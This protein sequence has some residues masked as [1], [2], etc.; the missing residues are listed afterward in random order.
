MENGANIDAKDKYGHTILTESVI[1][2]RLA[3]VKYLVEHGANIYTE[4]KKGH[5]LIS[6][7]SKNGYPE[8]VDYLQA[9]VLLK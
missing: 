5:T 4:N 3:C 9:K 8:I 1:N 7:A 6:L 2:V